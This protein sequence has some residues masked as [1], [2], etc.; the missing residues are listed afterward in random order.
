MVAQRRIMAAQRRTIAAQRQ[1]IAAERRNIEAERR[2]MEAQRRVMD[3][4]NVATT[5]NTKTDM[6]GKADQN[7]KTNGSKDSADGAFFSTMTLGM[8][9]LAGLNDVAYSMLEYEA[10]RTAD[11]IPVNEEE[12]KAGRKLLETFLEARL[13]GWWR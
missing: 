11:I 3:A 8:V 7:R 4:E 5:L 10:K 1:T 2:T 6:A 9:C 13:E 12:R